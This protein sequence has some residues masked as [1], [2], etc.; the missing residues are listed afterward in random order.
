MAFRIKPKKTDEN[1]S[2]Y[3]LKIVGNIRKSQSITTYGPGSLIDFPRMSGI[4][5][6]I[7]NWENS[8]GKSEFKKLKIHEAPVQEVKKEK[9]IIKRFFKNETIMSMLW[10]LAMLCLI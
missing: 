4:I 7:D 3:H 8:L 2:I 6:G 10:A 9:S 5:N 1:N